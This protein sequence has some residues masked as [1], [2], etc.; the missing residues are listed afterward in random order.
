MGFAKANE[1][2]QTLMG[3]RGPGVKPTETDWGT[4]AAAQAAAA[5]L[6]GVMGP[7]KPVAKSG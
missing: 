5:R 4:S 1:E 7:A 2:L 3:N 6:S